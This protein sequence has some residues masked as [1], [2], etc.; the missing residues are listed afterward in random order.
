MQSHMLKSIFFLLMMVLFGCQP[1]SPEN[2]P[3]ELK[4]ENYAGELKIIKLEKNGEVYSFLY[5][6]GGGY[7][8]LD[9]AYAEVFGCT[10]YGKSVGFRLSGEQV[11]SQNCNPVTLDIDGFIVTTTPKVMDI[12]SFL[13]EGLPRLAGLISLQTF[14]DYLVTIDYSAALVTIETP[15]SFQSRTSGMTEIPLKVSHELNGE[16]VTMFTQVL[17]T[18]EPLW[19][20]LDSGNLRGVLVAPHAAEILGLEGESS[21]SFQIAGQAYDTTGEVMDMIYDGALDVHF[22]KAYEITLD[23]KNSRAWVKRTPAE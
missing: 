10:P 15:E 18:P 7:T 22:F 3:F 20:Y 14:Q 1:A 9:A 8:V 6:T 12:N 4:L 11:E 23:L 2:S 5:D 17:E 16:A 19:F 13:P 21:L